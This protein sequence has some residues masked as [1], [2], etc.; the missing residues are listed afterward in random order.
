[1]VSETISRKTKERSPNFP[2]ITLEQALERAQQFY[3]QEKRGSAPFSSAAK[4]WSY[5]PTSSGAMQTVA[6]LKNYGLMEDEGTGT[7]RKLKLSNLAQRILLDKRPDSIER[8]LYKQQAALTPTIAAEIHEK[9]PDSLPSEATLNHFLVL[10]RGFNQTTAIKVSKIIQENESFTKNIPSDTLS[11]EDETSFDLLSVPGAETTMP[12]S[13]K[14][15]PTDSA[16]AT[17]IRQDVFTLDEGQVVLRWPSNMSASSY[18]DFKT[19]IELQLR[20]IG[21]SIEKEDT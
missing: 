2:F 14:V 5:S 9:W 19:W 1:M 6:A 16:T 12:V 4:H 18:E 11:T 10:E 20:K 13:D 17:L 15:T 8:E 7:S 3:D 21:R